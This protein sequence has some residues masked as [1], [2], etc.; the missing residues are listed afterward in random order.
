MMG[1]WMGSHFTNDDLVKD[2]RLVDQ[3]DIETGFEGERGGGT[4]LAQEV[5]TPFR[6]GVAAQAHVRQLGARG[7]RLAKRDVAVADRVAH[8]DEIAA[9]LDADLRGG[10]E[11]GRREEIGIE[12]LPFDYTFY[13]IGGGMDYF[14]YLDNQSDGNALND[15]LAERKPFVG[16]LVD[17]IDQE[18]ASAV[19]EAPGKRGMPPM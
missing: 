2:S 15:R 9:S 5:R 18:M 6:I 16:A 1:S 4:G 3:Y 10:V 11:E 12:I 8:V 14:H 7:R 13:C 17:E 19:S